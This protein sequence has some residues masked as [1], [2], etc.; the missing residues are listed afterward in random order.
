[1]IVKTYVGIFTMGG[2]PWN[3]VWPKSAVSMACK[4]TQRFQAESI[5][6]GEDKI[7][8][9]E[10]G[11]YLLKDGFSGKVYLLKKEFFESFFETLGDADGGE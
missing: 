5:E 2:L 8:E 4:M 11:D 10:K 9:G 7:V 1:M 6:V 3:K